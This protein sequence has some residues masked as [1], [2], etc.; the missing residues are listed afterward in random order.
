MKQTIAVDFD[1]VLHKYIRPWRGEQVIPDGPSDGARDAIEKLRQTFRVVVY[2]VRATMP[3]GVQAIRLWLATHEIVVDDVVA[4]KPKAVLYVDDR[5]FRFDGD[6]KKVL[7]FASKPK[8]L[9]PWNEEQRLAHREWSG[10]E[11]REN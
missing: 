7:T 11:Q 6:W 4:E 5:G 3:A 8:N 2:S 1:G 10:P 9:A